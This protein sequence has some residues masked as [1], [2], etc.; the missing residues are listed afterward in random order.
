MITVKDLEAIEEMKKKAKE[1][2][3]LA[4]MDSMSESNGLLMARFTL[5]G[6]PGRNQAEGE[7][8]DE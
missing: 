1:L 4:G 2:G 5:Y 7:P 6:N 3:Y 8:K